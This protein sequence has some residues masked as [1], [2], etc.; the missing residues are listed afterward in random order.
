MTERRRK[1]SPQSK[2]EAVQ[3]VRLP[4]AARLGLNFQ[5]VPVRASMVR[6]VAMDSGTAAPMQPGLAM[7]GCAPAFRALAATGARPETR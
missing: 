2:A 4:A 6:A 1:L 7:D 5:E 3:M